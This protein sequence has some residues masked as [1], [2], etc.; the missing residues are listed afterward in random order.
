MGT[1]E[2]ILGILALLAAVGVPVVIA[3]FRAIL[4]LSREQAATRALLK[5][6]LGHL[7]SNHLRHI[8]RALRVLVRR[9]RRIE[10]RHHD[11]DADTK[12]A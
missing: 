12:G 11:D 2:L 9:V 3:G 5:A 4:R 8:Y 6:E 7:K 1:D 10:Q